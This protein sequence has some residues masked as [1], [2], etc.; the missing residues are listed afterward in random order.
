MAN[1]TTV[2]HTAFATQVMESF[3][4]DAVTRPAADRTPPTLRR[5]MDGRRA[6]WR[7]V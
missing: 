3:G 1:A 7:P 4:Q 5:R 6:G 2:F